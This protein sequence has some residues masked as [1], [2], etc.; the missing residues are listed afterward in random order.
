[1]CRQSSPKFSMK[2]ESY[3]WF[4]IFLSTIYVYTYTHKFESQ[5]ETKKL[6]DVIANKFEQVSRTER[7]FRQ[8]D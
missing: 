4:L 6:H 5:D 2:L 3:D 1:M 7:N 8:D